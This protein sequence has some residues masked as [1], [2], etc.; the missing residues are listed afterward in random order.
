MKIVPRS[1]PLLL[2]SLCFIALVACAPRRETTLS[3]VLP[4][5]QRCTQL[6]PHAKV[7]LGGWSSAELSRIQAL[8]T[9]GVLVASASCQGV[10]V[11]PS[12]SLEG[13]YLYLG[14]M[15]E[16]SEVTFDDGDQIGVNTG[17]TGVEA[18]KH[19]R[20]MSV[21]RVG[22]LA[23]TRVRAV[24]AD[25]RG[26]CASAS[27]F[28]RSLSVG[29][30]A[31]DT[32]LPSSCRELEPST[33][34]PPPDCRTLLRMELM[35][36]DG[37]RLDRARV[38]TSFCPE[39]WRWAHN[40]CVQA[41]KGVVFECLDDPQECEAECRLGDAASCT[42]LGFLVE[43]GLNG[44][45]QDPA[46][47]VDLYADACTLGH[48]PA[49][50][51]L[52]VA[53]MGP[54]NDGGDAGPRA[55]ELFRRACDRGLAMACSNLGTLEMAGVEAS[56]DRVAALDAFF[57]ACAGGDPIGCL[58]AGRA[59]RGSGVTTQDLRTMFRRSCEGE[60]SAGCAEAV[61][62]GQESGF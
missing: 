21:V 53:V 34:A 60:I 52:G 20:R 8:T 59:G 44:A 62:L 9:K 32:S 16:E 50:H 45:R 12:C 30:L 19:P 36:I 42:R 51:N 57:R 28:V 14:S 58:N 1:R 24:P 49:C 47:A 29:A 17:K 5:A 31:Q 61:K 7:F 6:G 22:R 2:L 23:T 38:E 4:A 56:A 40:R 27:H 39:G 54:A 41:R 25:L 11:L 26:A 10:I 55:L 33:Q 37:N 15:P 13:E 46:R 3:A 18:Q 48:A 35:P 43:H